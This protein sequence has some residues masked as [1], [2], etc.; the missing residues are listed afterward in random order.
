MKNAEDETTKTSKKMVTTVTDDIIAKSM[1]NS[2]FVSPVL[3]PM[4]H[5]CD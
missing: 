5:T 2:Q 4:S 3:V 1:I